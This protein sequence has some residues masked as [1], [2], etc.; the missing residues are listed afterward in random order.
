MPELVQSLVNVDDCATG[1]RLIAER[2]RDPFP[3]KI[4]FTTFTLYYNQSNWVT[5]DAL[6][7]HWERASVDAEVTGDSAVA[8]STKNVTAL[9]LSMG[10]GACPLDVARPPIVAIDDQ[11]LAAPVPGSDRSWTAHFRK[12]G[13]KW[14]VVDT[15]EVAGLHKR[16]GLQGPIDDAFLDSFVFVSPTG[17]PLAPPY[18]NGLPPK[19]SAP[20]PNGIASF[21]AT[22]RCVTI[23]TSPTPISLPAIWS[24]GATRAA[25]AFSRASPIACP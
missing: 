12:N 2:G 20:S 19:R 4:R 15:V 22:P 17:T 5:V 6:G 21:A 16:H 9:T 10:P 7:K 14:A 18:R 13:A 8:I 24:S 3:R 1:L 23:R 25:T 11:R